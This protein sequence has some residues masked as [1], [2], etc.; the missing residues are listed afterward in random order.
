MVYGDRRSALIENIRKEFGSSAEITG[1]QAGMHLS[2][3]LSGIGD[4]EIAARA[5]DES[6]WLVPLSSSYLT[7][8][9]RPGFILGFGSTRAE[10]MPAAVRKMRALIG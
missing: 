9:Q 10:Q 5:A 2:M 7:K 6:L 4:R 8:P 3:A 1:G